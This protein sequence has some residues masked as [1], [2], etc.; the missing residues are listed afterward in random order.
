MNGY[1]DAFLLM[2][3]FG[4]MLVRCFCLCFLHLNYYTTR[5]FKVILSLFQLF[6]YVIKILKAEILKN[7]D[8]QLQILQ[9]Q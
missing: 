5:Y 1:L 9:C 3:R 8:P 4:G 6:D 7:Q 2:K